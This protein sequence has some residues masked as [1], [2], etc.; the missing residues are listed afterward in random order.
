MSVIVELGG[1]MYLKKWEA[2][3]YAQKE[4]ITRNGRGNNKTVQHSK[5]K[6][7]ESDQVGEFGQKVKQQK[8]HGFASE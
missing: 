4:G 3:K 7:T 6:D 1:K 5:N 2:H 8:K